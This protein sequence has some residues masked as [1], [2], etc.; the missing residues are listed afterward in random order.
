MVSKNFV[1]MRA[2]QTRR[3]YKIPGCSDHHHRPINAIY[4]SRSNTVK[5]ELSKCLGAYMLNRW[6][7][8]VFT[9][10][11]LAALSLLDSASMRAMES[12]DATVRS[13][14]ITEAVP[15]DQNWRRIDLVKLDTDQHIEFE[16]NP[17]IKKE[18]SVTYYI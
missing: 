13:D 3:R 14:F 12:F 5:H 6:G 10:E 9:D 11:V 16:T 17:K 2:E 4:V 8:I 18:G 7:D 15:K 1:K